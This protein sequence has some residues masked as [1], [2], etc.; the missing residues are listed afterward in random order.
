MSLTDAEV[1]VCRGVARRS[2][3]ILAI[4]VWNVLARLG[5]AVPLGKTK[6]DYVNVVLFLPIANKEVVRLYIAVKEMPRMHILDALQ[7]RW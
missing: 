6:I 7:L 3:E 2:R 1:R 4:A 5:I